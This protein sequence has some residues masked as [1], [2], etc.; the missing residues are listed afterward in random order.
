MNSTQ[1]KLTDTQIEVINAQFKA[2]TEKLTASVPDLANIVNKNLIQIEKVNNNRNDS[3]I[4][5]PIIEQPKSKF[6]DLWAEEDDD[7]DDN[8]NINNQS[9]ISQ[10]RTVNSSFHIQKVK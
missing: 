9:Q 5:K 4:K 8:N 2:T 6:N 10:S 7:D 3:S 1:N